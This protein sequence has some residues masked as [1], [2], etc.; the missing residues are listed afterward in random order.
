M[1]GCAVIV[2]WAAAVLMSSLVHP[3]A[4]VERVAL[5]FHLAALLLGF[6][7]VLF[8]DWQCVLFVA[9]RRTHREVVSVVCTAHP[10]V[11]TGLATLV[12][13]GIF[14][15]PDL[16]AG[17]MWGKLSLVLLLALN[18]VAAGRLSTRLRELGDRVPTRRLLVLG[19]VVAVVSQ[20]CWWGATLI[21][22]LDAT[23]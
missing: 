2:V 13:S 11:W 21:G 10:L 6:G 17:L 22:F 14:L 16:T 20:A 9:R 18:G 19:G 5:F 23:S 7:A 8:V 12:A 1:I 4:L 3:G 15:R